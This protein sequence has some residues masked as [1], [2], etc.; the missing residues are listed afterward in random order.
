MGMG[1]E[2]RFVRIF[3][4]ISMIPFIYIVYTLLVGLAG[5]AAK[6]EDDEYEDEEAV[7]PIVV[8]DSA[9]AARLAMLMSSAPD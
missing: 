3:W 2:N 8:G 5:P 7:Q 4:A 6:D 9:D 1:I